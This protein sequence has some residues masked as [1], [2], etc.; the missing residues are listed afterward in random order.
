M[1]RGSWKTASVSFFCI[2]S[3]FSIVFN[4][5]KNSTAPVKWAVRLI[6]GSE[7][8][9]G[10]VVKYGTAVQIAGNVLSERIVYDQ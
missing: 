10:L 8:K 7:H 5:F 3:F 4:R 9:S 2:I 1:K 6:Y